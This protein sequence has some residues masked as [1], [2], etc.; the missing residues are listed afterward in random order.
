MFRL[1]AIGVS[2]FLRAIV[3]ATVTFLQFG[4]T[5][6]FVRVGRETLQR[7]FFS[8]PASAALRRQAYRTLDTLHNS[9]A[10][11]ISLHR[12]LFGPC[13][14]TF[15]CFVS[16][17]HLAIRREIDASASLDKGTLFSCAKA[18]SQMPEVLYP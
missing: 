9:A 6:H 14:A 12:V 3:H 1:P 5:L 10:C 4:A 16:A 15:K 17:G 7:P 18:K 13:S 11:G 8:I 2:A